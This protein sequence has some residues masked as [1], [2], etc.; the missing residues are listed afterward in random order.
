MMAMV[1]A[2]NTLIDQ[3]SPFRAAQKILTP[4]EHRGGEAQ[5]FLEVSPPA[6]ASRR[7]VRE[8]M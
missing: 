8:R 7:I 6:A 3:E 1:V 2:G 4:P 5:V